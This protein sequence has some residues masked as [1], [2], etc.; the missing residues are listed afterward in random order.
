MKKEFFSKDIEAFDKLY[1]SSFINSLGGFKSVVLIGTCNSQKQENLSIFSSLFHIG[2]NPALCG[3]VVRPSEVPRHTLNNIL[4]TKSYTVN[5][6]TEDF[7][8]NAHQTSARY[9]QSESEFEAVKL[10]PEYK[11]SILAPFVKES[12]LNFACELQQK[13]DLE[14]NG[15]ILLIGKIV[16][17]NVPESSIMNDGFI[18]LEKSGSITVSGLD[19][20]HAT[21]NIERLSYAKVNKWPERIG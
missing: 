7:Y 2:A 6:I 5:H 15:T 19:S 11:H 10:I 20:Y 4:E 14:I 13:I 12:K 18:D 9:N 21:K 3:I 17:V 1:R 16:Y 8:K